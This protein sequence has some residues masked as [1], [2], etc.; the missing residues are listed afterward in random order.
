MV[1]QKL[2]LDFELCPIDETHR[3]TIIL[4]ASKAC[5]QIPSRGDPVLSLL[6][7]REKGHSARTLKS[8]VLPLVSRF[9][10]ACALQIDTEVD[11]AGARVSTSTQDLLPVS[12]AKDVLPLPS[13]PPH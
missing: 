8:Q 6:C 2:N 9:N 1:V 12:L 13:S 10:S 5:L 4:K 11:R 7:A 3:S